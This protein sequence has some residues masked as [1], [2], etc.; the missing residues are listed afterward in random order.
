M[1]SAPEGAARRGAKPDG[2]QRTT[3][4]GEAR[5]PRDG[6]R[7][8]SSD[9]EA[10]ERTLTGSS[11]PTSRD[12]N[13]D[14]ARGLLSRQCICRHEPDAGSKNDLTTRHRNATDK[15]VARAGRSGGKAPRYSTVL[16]A[17]GRDEVRE[18]VL[19]RFKARGGERN[20]WAVP[21]SDVM[22]E[23]L[24]RAEDWLEVEHPRWPERGTLAAVRRKLEACV[25]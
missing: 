7:A 8:V 12:T 13:V 14:F 21:D 3:D 9:A 11:A 22:A 5:P 4:H 23:A 2:R 10:V 6:S 25:T 15:S 1:T 24:T 20:R 16:G 17:L 18:R 19:D